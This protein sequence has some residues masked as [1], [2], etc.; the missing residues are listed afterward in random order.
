MYK[1]PLWQ[2]LQEHDFAGLQ[3][4]AESEVQAYYIEA[5]GRSNKRMRQ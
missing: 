3:K 5:L 1:S 4:L 2:K